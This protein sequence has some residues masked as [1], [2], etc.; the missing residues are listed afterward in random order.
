MQNYSFMHSFFI[1]IFTF[2]VLFAKIIPAGIIYFVCQ[3]NL[4]KALLSYSDIEFF[5]NIGGFLCAIA[6]FLLYLS[7]LKF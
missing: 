3:I 6:G 4:I 7:I 5:M 1:E 2:V